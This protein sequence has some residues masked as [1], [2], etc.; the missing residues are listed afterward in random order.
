MGKHRKILLYLLFGTVTTF[1]NWAVYIPLYYY[2]RQAAVS[3][4]IAWLAAVIVSY[5]TNKPFV[6]GNHDWSLKRIFSEFSRFI[7]CRFATGLLE[8]VCIF[9]FSDLLT[10]DGALIKLLVSICL[11]IL[12]YLSSLLLFRHE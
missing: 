11:V 9:V 2:T 8:T 1:V 3:N 5:L 6:F 10:I 4:G 12:N 7:A